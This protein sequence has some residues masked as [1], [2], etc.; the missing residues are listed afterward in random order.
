VPVKII[1]LKAILPY[2]SNLLA[3]AGI[4]GEISQ[5]D[6]LRLPMILEQTKPDLVVLCHGG[7]ELIRQ[8][9]ND[10]LK[11]NIENQ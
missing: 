6:L 3:N 10:Q 8:L 1:K 7:N 2:Y 5:Q 9:G 4:L 11:N